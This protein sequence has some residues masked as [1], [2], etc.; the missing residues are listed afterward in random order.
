[1]DAERILIASLLRIL[2]PLL[3]LKWPILGVA[4]SVYADKEDFNILGLNTQTDFYLIWDKIFDL[5]FLG[6]ALFV[7]MRW[8][9]KLA[10]NLAIFFFLYRLLGI[11]LFTVVEHRIILFLFPNFLL[12]Y[13]FIYSMF[14]RFS[15]ETKL[16]DSKMSLFLILFAVAFPTV[17]Q[18]Y[19]MHI[20]QSP[21]AD[22]FGIKRYFVGPVDVSYW[23]PWAAEAL[24]PLSVLYWRIKKKPVHE[25]VK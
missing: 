20:A 19:F 13:F 22:V 16:F 11:V 2:A 18:E 15:K 9:E 23:A 4:A 25:S 21:P 10:R 1:M 3:I 6:F 8:K 14:L 7:A 17:T 5:Y 12:L 24:I